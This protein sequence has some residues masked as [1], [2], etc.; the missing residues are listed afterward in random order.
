[1]AVKTPTY[2]SKKHIALVMFFLLAAGVISYI[3]LE[4]RWISGTTAV[5]TFDQ[6]AYVEKT[7]AIADRVAENPLQIINPFTYLGDPHANRPPLMMMLA[8]FLGRTAEPAAMAVVW[9]IARLLILAGALGYIS[10][11]LKNAWWVP[12][13]ALTVL[14]APGWLKVYPNL[15]MMDQ[16][17][18]AAVL[19]ALACIAWDWRVR[20]AGSAVAAVMAFL[21]ALMIKPA[22]AILFAPWL[23]VLAWHLARG[24]I[25]GARLVVY[26]AGMTVLI[27]LA[28][29]P[30]GRA[31]VEL[32]LLG[33][34]GYW[35]FATPWHQKILMISLLVPLWLIVAVV[36]RGLIAGRKSEPASTHDARWLLIPAVIVVAWWYGF[37]A[38]ITFSFDPRIIPAAM[39]IAV[40]AACIEAARNW[41]SGLILTIIAAIFFEVSL[42]VVSGRIPQ[43]WLTPWLEP[44]PTIKEVGLRD[45]ALMMKDTDEL[46]GRRVMIA[47]GDDFVELAAFRVAMRLTPGYADFEMN[48]YP[49]G[50]DPNVIDTLLSYDFILRKHKRARTK[51][52]S[53]VWISLHAIESLME[54]EKSPLRGHFEPVWSAQIFQ[55]DLTDDV[56]LYRIDKNIPS[57][58]HQRAVKY[59]ES[60]F[61]DR[62]TGKK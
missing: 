3:M 61:H 24:K 58:V 50:T 55:P 51:L 28:L 30:F 31:S 29:S 26:L 42:L 27:L 57:D 33:M 48:S 25:R 8:A 13:A 7:W 5:P 47:S 10:W 43:Q 23:I 52:A 62:D 20:T 45:V 39:A 36:I 15:L 16:C 18:E 37:N 56:T 32:Y 34:Q 49:W 2:V 11:R 41:R 38:W 17:F 40:S 59:A 22:A 4:M 60:L 46:R 19:L 1:M 14:C 54:D 6:A 53:H 35:N 44:Q 21:I 12:A 9:L